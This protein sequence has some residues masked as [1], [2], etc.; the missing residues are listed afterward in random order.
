VSDCKTQ[1]NHKW[2]DSHPSLRCPGGAVKVLNGGAELGVVTL[3]VAVSTVGFSVCPPINE[4]IVKMGAADNILRR[5]SKAVV[6]FI[7]TMKLDASPE[8]RLGNVTILL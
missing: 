7:L 4:P 8:Q 6:M 2:G 3:E 1:M 5:E